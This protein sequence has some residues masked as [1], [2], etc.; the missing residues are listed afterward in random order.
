MM[1]TV[2][3]VCGGAGDVEGARRYL[4]RLLAPAMAPCVPAFVLP[5]VLQPS[6][7]PTPPHLESQTP[8]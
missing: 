8:P 7:K 1:A 6:M 4:D 3:N 5:A 2:I